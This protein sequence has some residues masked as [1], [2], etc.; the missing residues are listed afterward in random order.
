[1]IT[2]FQ[3]ARSYARNPGMLFP[4]SAA[5]KTSLWRLYRNTKPDGAPKEVFA[6]MVQ[7]FAGGGEDACL[8][9]ENV[10]AWVR[11]VDNEY[12]TIEVAFRRSDAWI[13]G[14]KG[15]MHGASGT[16]FHASDRSRLELLGGLYC[17]RPGPES[18]LPLAVSRD[19]QIALSLSSFGGTKLNVPVQSVI[20]RD[21]R[22]GQVTQIT[23]SQFPP[24]RAICPGEKIILLLVNR[25]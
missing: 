10:H 8:A 18:S 23:D 14:Y 7:G 2:W 22:K 21:E 9:V 12:Y 20:L 11:Q 5:Q 15:E 3:H 4:G 6:N 25:P 24:R 17:V 16:F 13:L 1:M 19:S